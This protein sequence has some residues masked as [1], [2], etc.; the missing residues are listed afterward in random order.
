MIRVRL[1]GGFSLSVGPR[2]IEESAWRLRKAAGLVKLLA[3][4]P[5]HRIHRDQMMHL[6][7][8]ELNTK[9]AANNLRRTLHVARRTLEPAA[10]ATASLYYLRLEGDLLVLCS[11][12]TLWVDVEAFEEAAATARELREPA[13]YRAAL[14]LY[15]GDLLP[16]DL[17]EEWV[18]ERREQLRRTYL[19]LLVEMAALHEERKDFRAATETLTKVVTDEP[20][21]EG[22]H[23][24][25]MHLYALSG[26]HQTGLAQY[27]QL[28]EALR[29]ELGREPN[30]ASQRLYEEIL[31]GRL[32][33]PAP[34]QPP[35]GS[36]QK[37]EPADEGGKHNLPASLSSFVGR[38]RELVEAK[39]ML[40]MTR[41]LTLTGAGGS[42]K[43]RVALE[44]AKDL[45]GAYPDGVWLVELASLAEGT[46][47]PQA[48]AEALGASEEPGRTLI[49]ALVDVLRSK[50]MLLVLDNCEHL[51]GAAARLTETLL[52]ACAGLRVLATSRQA[53]GVQ[54]EATW[55]VPP[56]SGPDPQKRHTVEKLGGYESVRLFVERARSRAP[57][58]ALDPKNAPAVEEICWRLEGMPLAIE[59]AATRVGTLGVEQISE[60]LGD[61]LKLLICSSRTATRRQ[62]TLRGTLD[63]SFELLDE[64]ERKLFG[65]L[66]V[67]AGGWTLEAAEVVGAGDGIEE[68]EV[69][70]LL[71]Q[72]V[73]RSLVVI[74]ST[75]EGRVR[76]RMLEPVRQYAQERLEESGEADAV[77]SRHATFFLGLAEE[78]EP[79]LQ[80]PRQGAW[81]EQL[82]REHDNLRAALSWSLGSGETELGLRL[83]GAL[84]SFWA[85]LGYLQEG[86]SWLEAT[87]AKATLANTDEASVPARAKAVVGA[88]E[89]A[90]EQGDHERSRTLLEEGLVLFRQL[91]DEVGVAS[92]LSNLGTA[93]LFQNELE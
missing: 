22:A 51:L 90:W 88:G 29:R 89:I 93:A 69:L 3:L 13:P 43:T 77:R 61:S 68:G 54:G 91:G 79:E 39:R 47:V 12:G 23:V 92:T 80:G 10:S 30:A 9:A 71:S 58:F 2:T 27:E 41:L 67:F 78:A 66:S 11:N 14:D 86:R 84:S 33:P 65:R 44:V 8:P 64:P 74:E 1:L 82:E 15:A 4:T 16:G 19:D 5:G 35:V 26:Q 76:F 6:L 53:L 40:A 75:G 62:R 37:K 49:E 28:R 85:V 59:L 42:G 17:Y 55:L 25:L 24:G 34:S 20:T 45:V 31:T 81:L 63:W 21:H 87:L 60:R 18:Q 83:S 56:L 36:P 70:G 32:L 73:D 7:W 57:A 46:L 72:L 52:G 38:E 48:M 50:Q